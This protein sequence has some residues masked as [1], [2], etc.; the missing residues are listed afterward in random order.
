MKR[1]TGVSQSAGADGPGREDDSHLG[2]P[3][4]GPSSCPKGDE[5]ADSVGGL[6]RPVWCDL[7]PVS[8]IQEP[9]LLRH[10]ASPLVTCAVGGN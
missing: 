5:R 9:H 4:G 10:M 6:D 7:G 8:I 1:H 2:R 3:T